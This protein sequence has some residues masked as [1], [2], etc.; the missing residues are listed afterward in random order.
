MAQLVDE[1]N[2]VPPLLDKLFL[3]VETRALFVEGIYRKCGSIAHVRSARKAI[4]TN[5]GRWPCLL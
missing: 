1:D 5:T 3:A 4:E 2:T